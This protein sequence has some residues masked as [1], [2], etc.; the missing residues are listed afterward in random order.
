MVDPELLA[1]ANYHAKLSCTMWNKNRLSRIYHR[2]KGYELA[3]R[4]YLMPEHQ[5]RVRQY[6][7]GYHDINTY[8]PL[9][10][11]HDYGNWE[12]NDEPDKYNLLTDPSK[13]IIRF[14]P[15]YCN[16]KIG[17][18]IGY[19]P[20]RKTQTLYHAKKWRSYLA[21]IGFNKLLP[22]DAKLKDGCCYV[23]IDPDV[24]EYGLVVWFEGTLDFG[25]K[26]KTSTYLNNDYTQMIVTPD[27]FSWVA[28]E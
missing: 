15:S 4:A 25:R 20:T 16:Q 28:I 7:A 8:N 26:I 23:G 27:Q 2:Q 12:L 22:S 9:Y 3:K 11:C 24:G 10:A 21:E 5:E 13:F 14:A 17:E 1:E 6:K 18:R 19:L